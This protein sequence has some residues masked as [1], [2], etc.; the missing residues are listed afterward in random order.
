[1]KLSVCAF[2]TGP[3]RVQSDFTP[4]RAPFLWSELPAAPQCR[5]FNGSAL[6]S[7]LGL[8]DQYEGVLGLDC[9]AYNDAVLSGSTF[10]ARFGMTDIDDMDFLYALFYVN[11]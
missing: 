6:S 1:M 3:A 11:T 7:P 5:I 9:I 4:F 10:E 8:F 2:H